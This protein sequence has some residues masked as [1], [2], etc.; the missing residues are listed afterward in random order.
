MNSWQNNPNSID[1]IIALQWS[2]QEGSN[3]TNVI[4]Q[5][6]QSRDD[7]DELQKLEL[8]EI[9][10]LQEIEKVDQVVHVMKKDYDQIREQQI[11]D[12]HLHSAYS[13]IRPQSS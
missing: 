6:I 1:E 4:K 3:T 9:R 7:L 13:N 10:L 12:N 2:N 11:I 5:Q 8:E